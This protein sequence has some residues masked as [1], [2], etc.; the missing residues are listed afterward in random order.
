M[1]GRLAADRHFAGHGWGKVLL[2]DALRRNLVQS[3]EI[4]GMAVVVDANGANA[5]RFY[6]CD[7]F[8]QLV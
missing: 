7:G 3:R 2:V 4:A 5:C 8:R 1:I 6:E